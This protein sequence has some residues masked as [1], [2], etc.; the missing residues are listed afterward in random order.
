MALASSLEPGP[1]TPPGRASP[2]LL[3]RTTEAP[4]RT[5][6]EAGCGIPLRTLVSNE[7][8]NFGG[9]PRAARRRA[10]EAPGEAR[11]WANQS[12]CPNSPNIITQDTYPT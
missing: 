4:L 8:L 1:G 9:V 7:L 6:I 10:T 3:S 2:R 11:W 12:K 5:P